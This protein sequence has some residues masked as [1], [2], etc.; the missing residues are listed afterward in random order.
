M[1]ATSLFS[2]LLLLSAVSGMRSIAQDAAPDDAAGEA[3]RKR[4]AIA[5][6]ADPAALPTNAL[7]AP[8]TPNPAPS[9]EALSPPDSKPAQDAPPVL[10]ID[11]SDAVPQGFRDDRYEA[12]FKKNPFLTVTKGPP[13]PPGPGLADDWELKSM[14]DR[15]GV[16]SVTL[17]NKK[18]AQ[19]LHVGPEPD[20]KEGIRIVKMNQAATRKERSVEIA[21]GS[22]TATL[23]FSDSPSPT[24]PGGRSIV[25]MPNQPGSVP[26]RSPYNGNIA[27]P[28]PPGGIRPSGSNI[29]RPATNGVMPQ[30]IPQGQPNVQPQGMMP[31]GSGMQPSNSGRRRLLVPTP[32]P[33]TG[34]VPSPI[35]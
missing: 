35:R 17:L 24:A 2:F 34:V 28:T 18:T 15:N 23:S 9:G 22:D 13:L 20:K 19:Y 5:N 26:P 16:Q 21:R 25:P 8:A 6:G 30:N 11:A 4:L 3:A 1:K 12:T 32:A 31:G 7:P 29:P 14:V 10:M 33:A 27:V